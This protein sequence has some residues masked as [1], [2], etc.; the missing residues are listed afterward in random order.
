VADLDDGIYKVKGQYIIGGD[1]ITV[2]NCG[3]DCLFIV[4][5]DNDTTLL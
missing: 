3:N 4:T 2:R 1:D 5:H